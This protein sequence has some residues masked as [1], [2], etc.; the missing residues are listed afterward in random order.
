MARSNL[1]HA[2]QRISSI[3]WAVHSILC[4][5]SY[6]T[7]NVIR[8]APA[9]FCSDAEIQLGDLQTAL[10][11]LLTSVGCSA[12]FM[13]SEPLSTEGH[14]FRMEKKL[15]GISFMLWLV[16]YYV[17]SIDL[18]KTDYVYWLLDVTV[19]F[20]LRDNNKLQL[21]YHCLYNIFV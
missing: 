6:V 1:G 12:E 3:G 19:H 11:F 7:T 14:V 9:S 2:L 16:F 8:Y 15:F 5:W 20:L 10:I 17:N 4:L 18:W 21:G 13:F